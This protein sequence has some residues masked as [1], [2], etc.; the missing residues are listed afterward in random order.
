MSKYIIGD[1]HGSF[2]TLVDLMYKIFEDGGTY[3]D[4]V[5]V[6]DLID[7]GPKSRQVV[8]Y[9]MG[10]NIA[11]VLGN[12]ELMMIDW[13]NS[14][15]HEEGVW[16]RNGGTDTLASYGSKGQLFKDHVKFLNTLPMF[17]EYSECKNAVGEHL[18]VTHSAAGDVW[19]LDPKDP[20]FINALLWDRN[21]NPFPIDGIFNVFGHTPK[22]EPVIGKWWANVDTGACFVRGDYGKLTALKY[23]EMTIIQQENVDND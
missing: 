11:C 16:T 1:V 4:V 19:G 2:L 8:E 15:D 5:L 3:A 6:G 22:Q 21:A 20:K 18:L 17:L 9:V 23:P 12:H 13:E 10:N 7:R 14:G